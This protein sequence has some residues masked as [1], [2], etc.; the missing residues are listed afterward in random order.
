MP[1][2]NVLPSLSAA[3]TPVS[4]GNPAGDQ[5][6]SATGP[7]NFASELRRQISAAGQTATGANSD[8]KP[9]TTS[10]S[11]PAGNAAPEPA[12]KTAAADATAADPGA[13]GLAALVATSIQP[14][15]V[16][17]NAPGGTAGSGASA[18]K[19]AA[20]PAV[21]SGLLAG[22]LPASLPATAAGAAVHE[23]A[24]T[25]TIPTATATILKAAATTPKTVATL[26]TAAAVKTAIPAALSLPTGDSPAVHAKQAD[27]APSDSAFQN[28]LATAQAT[29]HATAP[30]TPLPVT[31]S[32]G[33]N[34]WASNVGD[35]LV[36]MAGS[37][38]QHA[39]LVLN[40]P[41]L[42][43][44][45]VS[46][47]LHGDQASAQFV[48]H[49]PE[50][51]DALEAALPR[52]REMLAGA[53]VNLGQTQV[54]SGATGDTGSQS[55]NNRGNGDNSSRAQAGLGLG[56]GASQPLNAASLWLRQGNGMVDVFA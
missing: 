22:A 7:G 6:S 17:V 4:S 31:A 23:E 29:T 52:L 5:S 3:P 30:A 45:E 51:R 12:K 36:W 28:L 47:S 55:P 54:G 38:T 11:Q 1:E 39:E 40:P 25:A 32:L 16:A 13:L 49:N 34:N 21:D 56:S 9:A 14:A 24:A 2:I 33:S 42:G 41:H 50:V 15:A 35:K 43:R 18:E 20:T 48:S 44:V 10:A 46:L 26:S 19:K 37:Q 27:A 53:G 8:S